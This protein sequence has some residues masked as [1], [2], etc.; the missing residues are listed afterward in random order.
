[1]F[2]GDLPVEDSLY[3]FMYCL[4]VKTDTQQITVDFSFYAV[5]WSYTCT[6]ETSPSY[7]SHG[8][9]Q[10]GYHNWNRKLPVSYILWSHWWMLH[11]YISLI[12]NNLC[13]ID[14][15]FNPLRIY[16][17]DNVTYWLPSFLEGNMHKNMLETEGMLVVSIPFI[18]WM[19]K[20]KSREVE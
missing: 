19:M 17:K 5:W 9:K 2:L 4:N 16:I 10:N 18:L 1:M 20:L 15:F 14:R 6:V 7:E 8:K 3:C 12:E 11:K 13:P